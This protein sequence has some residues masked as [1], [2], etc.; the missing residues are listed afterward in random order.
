[1][2]IDQTVSSF[3][4]EMG[5]LLRQRRE[6]AGISQKDLSELSG[7]SVHTISD[8]ERAKGNP[9]V[10]VIHRLFTCLGLEIVFRP[11]GTHPSTST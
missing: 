5:A 7:L 3:L 10:E 2:K 9:T 6:I 8:I 11:K 1:M 4:S